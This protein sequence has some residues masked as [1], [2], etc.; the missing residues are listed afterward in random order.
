M[1]ATES[2]P[3]RQIIGSILLPVQLRRGL[4]YLMELPTKI[5]LTKHSTGKTKPAHNSQDMETIHQQADG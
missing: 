2:S 3:G 5:C 1:G 4:R